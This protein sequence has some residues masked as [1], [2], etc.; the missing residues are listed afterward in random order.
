MPEKVKEQY[1]EIAKKAGYDLTKLVWTEQ[2]LKPAS[3]ELEEYDAL[4][5]K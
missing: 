1:L 4:L 2:R 3:L 5:M